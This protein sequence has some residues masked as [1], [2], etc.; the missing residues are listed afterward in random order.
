MKT[1]RTFIGSL[2]SLLPLLGGF[3]GACSS[4]KETPV[5]P[6]GDVSGLSEDALSV[7]QQLGYTE[8]SS[9]ADRTCVNCQLFVK[10]DQAL[11]CGS[12]LAMKGPV[13]VGGYCTVWAPI[14]T[15]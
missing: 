13:A 6:C 1:R 2:V 15:G 12:C 7:R 5:D 8:Q 11:P 9:I 10:E 3:P 4:K 14:D